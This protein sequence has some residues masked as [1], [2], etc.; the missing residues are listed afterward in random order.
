MRASPWWLAIP[1]AVQGACTMAALGGGIWRACRG[2]RRGSAVAWTLLAVLPTLWMAAY[3]EYLLTVAAADCQRPNLLTRCGEGAASLL[4]EPYVRFCYP[5][6]HEGERFVMWSASPHPDKKEMA[7]MDAHIRAMERAFGRQPIYKIYWVRGP[8]WGI[9]QRGGLGWA[10]GSQSASREPRPDGLDPVD[11]HEVAHCVLEE[12]CPPGSEVP[13]LFHEGWAELHSAAK[14]ESH[15]RECWDSQQVGRL[16][17]LRAL[18]APDCYYNSL[19]PMYS[20][21]SVLVEYI[22]K[23]F[24][25]EKLL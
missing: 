14:P 12:F 19:A 15:W 4:I 1:L 2:P 17:S 24:G 10:L 21:G 20:L 25:H 3:V 13:R 22:V 23:R 7:A 5:Y 6:R 11:R 18:T 8:V 9:G 16:P